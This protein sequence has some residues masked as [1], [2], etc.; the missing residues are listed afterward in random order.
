LDADEDDIRKSGLMRAR[1]FV[2][3]YA[4]MCVFLSRKQTDVRVNTS[5]ITDDEDYEILRHPH[6]IVIPFGT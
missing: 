3:V 4:Y 1:L 6:Y 2:C 5:S